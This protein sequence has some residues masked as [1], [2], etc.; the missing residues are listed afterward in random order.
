[1]LADADLAIRL[2][3]VGF[4]QSG[5]RHAVLA[6]DAH[7]AFARRYDV[8]AFADARR[9]NGLRRARRFVYRLVRSTG[10]DITRNDH[11]LAGPQRGAVAETIGLP[12][13]GCR[14]AIFAVS[15]THLRAHE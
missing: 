5:D 2:N 11:A 7:H 13:G 1:M 9:G 12:D 4:R 3:V 8:H 6:R 10:R 14:H 15:Y